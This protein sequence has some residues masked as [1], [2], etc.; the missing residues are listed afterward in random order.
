MEGDSTY[1]EEARYFLWHGIGEHEPTEF[2]KSL[3]VQKV[4]V[5]PLGTAGV[6]VKFKSAKGSHYFYYGVVEHNVKLPMIVNEGEVI[7]ELPGFVERKSFSKGE[8]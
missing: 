3:G 6:S 7:N 5:E 1:F 2:L 4:V 8:K